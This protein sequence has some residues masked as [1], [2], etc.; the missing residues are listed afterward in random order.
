MA[1]NILDVFKQSPG[2]FD[3]ATMAEAINVVPNMYGRL[4]EA[5]L[6]GTRNLE[7]TIA[8][9][10]RKQGKVNLLPSRQRGGPPS[11]GSSGKREAIPIQIPHFPHDDAILA[12]ALQNVRGFGTADLESVARK[13]SEKL[14]DMRANHDITL[15]WLRWGAVK[16]IVLDSDGTTELLNLFTAF[17]ITEEEIDFAF[18]TDTT[19]IR[20]VCLNI[21]EFIEENAKGQMYSGIRAFCSKT[22]FRALISH[23]MVV[24]AYERWLDSEMLRNDPRRAFPFGGITFE[25]HI[26]N[27]SQL[28]GTNHKFIPDDEARVVL[29]GAPGFLVTAFG[30]GTT[31]DTVNQPGR[32]IVVKQEVMKFD[33]GVEI[34]TQSNPLPYCTRPE[35]LVKLTMS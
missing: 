16:G 20:D 14:A 9:I 25:E 18:T 15:E 33:A 27:A 13:V 30:P 7:T 26:G 21:S 19:D 6:F 23:P 1:F 28:D 17:N 35:L 29:E 3:S 12:D 2:P 34:H 10:E 4:R 11:L 22:F 24:A 32:D 31:I 5:G 8:V